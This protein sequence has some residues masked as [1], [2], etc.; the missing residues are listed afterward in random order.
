MGRWNLKGIAIEAS[1]LQV[2]EQWQWVEWST[3]NPQSQVGGPT[4]SR[5][6]QLRRAFTIRKGF[7]QQ[8]ANKEKTKKVQRG[9]CGPLNLKY[10]P[11]FLLQKASVNS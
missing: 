5:N 10:E 1:G 8:Q 9:P 4:Q 3:K 7:K 11:S 6:T 2:L